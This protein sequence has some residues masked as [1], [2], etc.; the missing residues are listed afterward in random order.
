MLALAWNLKFPSSILIHL[1]VIVMTRPIDIYNYNI[2]MFVFNTSGNMKGGTWGGYP[3]PKKS[4]NLVTCWTR[5][6]YVQ[7]LH[8][9]ALG[10]NQ[11]SRLFGVIQAVKSRNLPYS[12]F[13]WYLLD[14]YGKSYHLICNMSMSVIEPWGAKEGFWG[15]GNCP[16]PQKKNNNQFVLLVPIDVFIEK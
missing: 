1:F 4:W 10:K 3:P 14:I 13:A 2:H 7:K 15:L 11:Y 12:H 16:P 8:K 6:V 9:I 5:W